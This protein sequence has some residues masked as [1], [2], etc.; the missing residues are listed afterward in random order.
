MYLC[1][2]EMYLNAFGLTNLFDHFP[3]TLYVRDHNG[4]V[5]LLLLVVVVVCQDAGVVVL[6]AGLV[7]TIELVLQL[8]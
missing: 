7:V 8:V 6:L 5:P 1:T 2:F 3:C 4:D